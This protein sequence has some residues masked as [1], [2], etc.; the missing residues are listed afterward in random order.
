[1]AIVIFRSMEGQRRALKAFDISM[2][3]QLKRKVLGLDF[4][5]AKAAPEPELVIVENLGIPKFKR[6]IGRYM[7]YMITG[8]ILLLFVFIML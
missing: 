2:M 8:L 7:L 6:L 5:S 3:E 1:M 4:L